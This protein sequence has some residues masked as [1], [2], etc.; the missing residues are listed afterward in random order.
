MTKTLEK[1]I[2]GQKWL[3]N[4]IDPE[5]VC[6]HWIE[7]MGAV[8]GAMSGAAVGGDV[9]AS[10]QLAFGNLVR[11]LP[12]GRLTFYR[13]LIFAKAMVDGVPALKALQAGKLTPGNANLG[14]LEGLIFNFDPFSGDAGQYLARVVVG[15]S[16]ESQTS[17]PDGPSGASSSSPG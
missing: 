16:T 8:A 15:D 4:T 7:V 14:L 3:F 1:E 5:I 11:A 9:L 6:D 12:P 17:T 13:S 2:N 10:S